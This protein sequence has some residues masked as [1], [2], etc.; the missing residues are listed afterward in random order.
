MRNGMPDPGGYGIGE[1][2]LQDGPRVQTVLCGEPDSWEIGMTLCAFGEVV[3][4]ADRKNF[5]MFC[6]GPEGWS[7]VRECWWRAGHRELRD[8][9]PPVRGSAGPCRG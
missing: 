4:R 6:F 9:A 5:V 1:V 8:A 2:D 7:T 3:D